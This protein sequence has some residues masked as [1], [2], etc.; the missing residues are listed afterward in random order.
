MSFGWS[1]G[2]VV[3]C[4]KLIKD[5]SEALNSSTGSVS[6]FTSLMFTLQSLEHTLVISEVLYQQGLAFHLPDQHKENAKLM[7][8]AIRREHE[9]CKILL[10]SFIQ[11]LKPY[12]NAFVR[13]SSMGLVRHARKLTWMMRKDDILKLERDLN[14]HMKSLQVSTN[15]LFHIQL[16]SNTQSTGDILSNIISM[17]SEIT[18]MVNSMQ[19]AM[20]QIPSSIGNPW[21]Y[22][23]TVILHDAI[24]RKVPLPMMLLDS[25]ENLHQ[26]LSFMYQGIHGRR[27]ILRK[28]YTLS[29]EAH[30]GT[31]VDESNWTSIVQPGIELSLNMVFPAASSWNI[32][33]CPRCDAPSMGSKLPGQRRRCHKCQLTFRIFDKERVVEVTEAK[34]ATKDNT[35][36]DCQGSNQAGQ[37]CT[38]IKKSS[39]SIN[40]IYRHNSIRASADL[41]FKSIHYHREVLVPRPNTADHSE[42]QLAKKEVRKFDPEEL[43]PLHKAA[44]KGALSELTRI[45]EE[46]T[47][48]DVNQPLPPSG[49]LGYKDMTMDFEGVTPIHLAA[50][51][52]K[53]RV[54][55]GLL[56]RQA[57][58]NAK[59]TDARSVLSWAIMGHSPERTVSLLIARGAELNHRDKEGGTH[60][61]FACRLGLTWLIH[62]LIEAGADINELADT[63][64]TSLHMGVQ[65]GSQAVVEIL[66]ESG[67]DSNVK[68][69]IGSSLHRAVSTGQTEISKTLIEYGS[70][71]EA[72]DK[73]GNTPLLLAC[74]Q[75]LTDLVEVLLESGANMF[76]KN[77]SGTTPLRVSL[78]RYS[79]HGGNDII[80]V[81]LERRNDL[82][83]LDGDSWSFLHYAVY[84]G[85]EDLT[86]TS[87][88]R[89]VDVSL[90]AFDGINALHL[91][92]QQGHVGAFK[93]LIQHCKHLVDSVAV[94]GYLMVPL[95]FAMVD[96]RDEIARLL[97]EN[98]ANANSATIEGVSILHAAA[99]NCFVT[100]T[101]LALDYGADVCG[102]DEDGL[103][104]LHYAAA[105][106]WERTARI[107]L[108]NGADI[109][110]VD[111]HGRTALHLA[112][113]L[114]K[115]ELVKTLLDYGAA[116]DD[117][118]VDK[119]TPLLTS[120]TNGCSEVAKILLDKSAGSNINHANI[121]GSTALH[122]A[123]AKGSDELVMKMLQ[124][125]ADINAVETISGGTPLTVVA[126]HG[127]ESTTKILLDHGADVT[128]TDLAGMSAVLH[129]LNRGCGEIANLL[130]KA[131]ADVN[132]PEKSRG[133]TPLHLAIFWPCKS[134]VE[135]L[136][137]HGAT[138]TSGSSEISS[139][140]HWA[141]KRNQESIVRILIAAGHPLDCKSK[142]AGKTPLHRAC[143]R[144]F[145]VIAEI[146][147]DHGASI[148][149]DD[150]GRTP[151]HLAVERRHSDVVRLL[152][153]HGA[154]VNARTHT[155]ES[156]MNIVSK[157]VEDTIAR[158]LI[159]AGAD[160]TTPASYGLSGDGLVVPYV[161]MYA[162]HNQEEMV[163]VLLEHG[164]DPTIQDIHGKNAM[165]FA[166]EGKAKDND[167]L[168]E[169]LR[170]AIVER[171]VGAAG[172]DLVLP[173]RAL[174]LGS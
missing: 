25:P 93:I 148:I 141:V 94:E 55:S 120:T 83:Q 19:A 98:G 32:Q 167:S 162:F 112:A 2:D 57:N 61:H 84:A 147:L 95:F 113:S 59:S 127:S 16:T 81:L 64:E 117:Q 46:D 91:A 34:D 70:D 108:E 47:D 153:R 24:G 28:E 23:E 58:I 36:T 7:T 160:V 3:A 37:S 6:D 79:T 134:S 31:L 11:S 51:Y 4:L 121:V 97:F 174:V 68:D 44:A 116:W 131:G 111:K 74:T 48:A 158:L 165:Q 100:V 139:P 151:L 138:F 96:G 114:D 157:T 67:A 5:V 107:L 10:G 8:D 92:A 173:V 54:I 102:V 105:R 38:G 60:L 168:L 14:I 76:I 171:T 159:E 109:E 49:F 77:V 135:L 137:E 155:N 123:V 133:W 106:G 110:A 9:C 50:F 169:L 78:D 66:L 132:T 104:P 69:K 72:L 86:Q 62:T 142:K 17:R 124:Y 75:G 82:Y 125:N 52:G 45:L 20:V 27:K 145:T 35:S 170:S 89:G 122:W 150:N 119:Q 87:I 40:G 85:L 53:T 163:E 99:G 29:D 30:D 166:L 152:L 88:D 129:A 103:T 146:L 90:I 43:P 13:G 80:R 22:N 161:H 21:E 154:D 128:T 144:G 143:D 126:I 1:V 41:L 101:K 73:D 130:I 164:C 39:E 136:I 15:G 33:R 149:P 115:V 56:T 156:P 140:L 18:T 71:I 42:S 12:S 63:G 118:D 65:S 26:L 172:E